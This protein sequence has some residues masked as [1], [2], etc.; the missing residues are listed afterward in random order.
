MAYRMGELS[1]KKVQKPDEWR[2]E[3]IGSIRKHGGILSRVANDLDIGR[4]TLARWLE[5]DPAL[6]KQVD[7]ARR[8]RLKQVA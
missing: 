4:S 3:L 6:Q 5:E 2:S 8:L 7:V 1:L